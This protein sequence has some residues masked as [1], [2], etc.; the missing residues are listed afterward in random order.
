MRLSGII[1]KIDDLINPIVVKEIRQSIN[2]RTIY[3]IIIGVLLL[4][5]GGLLIFMSDGIRE[6]NSGQGYFVMLLVILMLGYFLGVGMSAAGRFANERDKSSMDLMHATVLSPYSI[7]WGKIFSSMVMV[8]FI[9]SLC[10]PFMCVSYFLQGI[11]IVTILSWCYISF[12]IALPTVTGCLL[13]GTLGSSKGMRGLIIFVIVFILWTGISPLLF[14]YGGPTISGLGDSLATLIWTT[15][16]CLAVSGL[17][18]FFAVSIVSHVSSNRAFCLR[19]YIAVLWLASLVIAALYAL[20]MG[21]VDPFEIWFVQMSLIAVVITG[22]APAERLV[23][24]RRV[25][26]SVPDGKW[27][28]FVHFLFSSGAV[29]AIL[30]GVCMMLLN[31]GVLFLATTCWNEI[32]GSSSKDTSELLQIFSGIFAYI[33]FYSFFAITLKLGFNRFFPNVNGMVY[34]LFVVGACMLIPVVIEVL[35]SFDQIGSHSE[36]PYMFILSPLIFTNDSMRSVGMIVSAALAALGLL[37]HFSLIKSSLKVHR[38]LMPETVT[39]KEHE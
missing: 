31:C 19:Y 21:S 27:R 22:F 3:A 25:L 5:L 35:R 29:N 11:D 20:H 33:L 32:Y 28:R 10:V 30:F 12:V 38:R 9:F 24:S 2:S 18:Y 17:F 15:F 23:Q 13:L 6:R 26:K 1:N 36:S 34:S 37:L 14:H 8:V 16:Y 7:I 39:V 4:E